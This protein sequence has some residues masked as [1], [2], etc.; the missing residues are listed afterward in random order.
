M[1]AVYLRIVLVYY[2]AHVLAAARKR[3]QLFFPIKAAQ[4]FTRKKRICVQGCQIV[5]HDCQSTRSLCMVKHRVVGS[6]AQPLVFVVFVFVN[7]Q[8]FT[9]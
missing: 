4:Y 3:T 6:E 8:Q 5:A 7:H 1:H 2:L 9:G